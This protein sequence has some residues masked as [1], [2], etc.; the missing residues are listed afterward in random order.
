MSEPY[1]NWNHMDTQME[2]LDDVARALDY[3]DT[4][5]YNV[6]CEDRPQEVLDRIYKLY[7]EL[8]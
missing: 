3:R 2:Y 5:H 1:T 7:E 4:N 6:A 8:N